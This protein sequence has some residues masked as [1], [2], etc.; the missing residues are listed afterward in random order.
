VVR[1]GPA[2]VVVLFLMVLIGASICSRGNNG[3]DADLKIKDNHSI[4]VPSRAEIMTF[5]KEFLAAANDHDKEK[6]LACFS[7]D[8]VIEDPVGVEP[9]RSGGKDGKPQVAAF[10]ETGLARSDI[11]LFTREDI[12]CGMDVIRDAVATIVPEPDLFPGLSFEVH[13]YSFYQLAWED[14]KI[15]MYHLRAFWEMDK[16]NRQFIER[17]F[18]GLRLALRLIRNTLKYQGI[19]GYLGLYKAR[20]GIHDDGKKMVADFVG[21]VN[22]NDRDKFLSLFQDE[23]ATIKYVCNENEYKAEAYL[24][25]PGKKTHIAVSEL[26]SA[27]WF[28][29]CRFNLTENDVKT[30]GIAIFQFNPDSRKIAAL[31]FYWNP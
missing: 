30:Q 4:P 2:L 7:R 28:T 20:S 12:I 17:G 31:R 27:G 26:R 24:N 14:G 29:A 21:A 3:S 8:A 15:R 11:T 23:K 18:D 25:R 19:R 10:Y 6:V 5:L 16:I 9:I 1:K 22:G 13:T